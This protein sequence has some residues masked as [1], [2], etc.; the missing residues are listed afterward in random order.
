MMAGSRI[1]AV[2]FI[3]AL[4][5]IAAAHV[6]SL[7]LAQDQSQPQVRHL[8]FRCISS[9]DGKTQYRAYCANCH[10]EDGTGHGPDAAGL[11]PTPTDL[12]MIAQRNGG[13]FER[14]HVEADITRWDRV[15][16]SKMAV[17]DT[18]EVMPLFGPLFFKCYPDIQDRNMH[19]ANLVDYIKKLQAK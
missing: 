16:M 19:L 4:A 2:G 8:R 9:I 10:G 18:S 3:A 15:N 17:G 14:A 7:A 6:S 13:K 5:S 12:T 1:A 11:D